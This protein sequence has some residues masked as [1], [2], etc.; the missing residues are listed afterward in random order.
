MV[1][2]LSIGQELMGSL[3]IVLACTKIVTDILWRN[4]HYV[5][6]EKSLGLDVITRRAVGTLG[7]LHE[8]G[9]ALFCSGCQEGAIGETENCFVDP[10][11]GDQSQFFQHC[12]IFVGV[13]G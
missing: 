5:L 1:N 12:L 10:A 9:P 4:V 8:I 11:R 6:R 7:L 3:K 13:I 2:I